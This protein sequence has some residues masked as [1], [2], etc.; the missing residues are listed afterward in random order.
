MNRMQNYDF[1]STVL[2]PIEEG[3]RFEIG[4]ELSVE[5]VA[6]TATG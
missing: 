3:E 1:S 5:N 4:R 6:S 2:R